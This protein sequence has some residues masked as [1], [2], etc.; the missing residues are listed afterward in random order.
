MNIG[1]IITIDQCS[2]R[3]CVVEKQTAKMSN[4]KA[5]TFLNI[6]LAK[7]QCYQELKQHKILINALKEIVQSKNKKLKCQIKRQKHFQTLTLPNFNTIRKLK[8]H[9]ILQIEFCDFE[10]CH[11][12]FKEGCKRKLSKLGEPVEGLFISP[13]SPTT[14]DLE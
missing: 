9:R 5:K 12:I 3:N 2:Q 8:Q 4:K 13:K 10:S 1:S 14:C 6:N 7:F 11:K